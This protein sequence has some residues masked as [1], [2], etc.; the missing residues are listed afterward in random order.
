MESIP[1]Y[2]GSVF[3]LT[4]LRSSRNLRKP[5]PHLVRHLATFLPFS[6]TRIVQFFRSMTW[7]N[8]EEPRLSWFFLRK[9]HLKILLPEV[10]KELNNTFATSMHGAH[11]CVCPGLQARPG[12][13]SL[14]WRY[15]RCLPPLSFP[16][17][18]PATGALRLLISKP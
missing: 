8:M 16:G 10:V 12:F 15:S 6:S 1:L 5:T 7:K 14:P 2:E 4:T 3:T 9:A 18:L 17:T 13:Q 11:I